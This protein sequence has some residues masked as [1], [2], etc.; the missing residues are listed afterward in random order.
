MIRA[1]I[2]KELREQGLIGLTLLVLGSGLLAAATQANPPVEGA[3]PSDG[4]RYLGVGRLVTLMLAV[5][6]GMVCGGAVFA[7]E[8]EA[9]T[10]AFLESLP[11]S[12]RQIWRAKFTAG[13]TVTIGL[14]AV[15]LAVAASL[16]LVHRLGWAITVSLYALLAFVWGMFGSTAA[17]TTL[18]S[19][20]LAIPA[21]TLT[22]FVALIP[23]ILFFQNPGSMLPRPIGAGIFLVAMFATPLAVSFWLF[24]RS[25]RDRA[26]AET[27]SSGVGFHALYWLTFHQLLVPGLVI[28]LF[29]LS[30]GLALLLPG[31]QPFLAWPSLALA[32]GALSGVTAF[33]DEQSHGSARFWGE[34]RLPLGRAWLLKVTIHLLFCLWLLLLLAIP[35]AVHAQFSRPEGLATNYGGSALSAIFGTPLFDE[36]KQQGW[37]YLVIPAIYGFAAGHLCSLIF[38]KLVVAF[39]VAGVVGGVG[40]ALWGPSLLAGGVKNWQLWIPP[41]IILLT[42]RLLVRA[43]TADR[44]ATRRP[45][46]IL[47]GGSLAALLALVG[48]IGYR[49]LEIPD[50]PHGEDDIR[51]LANLLPL[52]ENVAGRDFKTAAERYSQASTT[53]SS[54]FEKPSA[55]PP[56]P[57]TIGSRRLRVEER[58]ELVPF[59]GWPADDPNLEAWLERLFTSKSSDRDGTS[60]HELV[61]SATERPLGIYEHPQMLGPSGVFGN[62][63]EYARRM[64]VA[65]LAR[66]LQQQ[67]RGDSTAFIPALRSTLTLARTMRNGSV[68]NCLIMGYDIERGALQA[69]DRW[70]E[71][72]PPQAA[73]LRVA[74][75][76]LPSPL[77]SVPAMAFEAATAA[78]QA[79]LLKMAIALLEVC[80]PIEPFDP[81]PQYLAERHVVREALKSLT[82]WL[83]QVLT[84]SPDT[85]GTTDPVIDLLSMAWA[86]PWEK[87][88]TRRLVGLGYEASLSTDQSLLSGRPGAN[89]LT[90]RRTPTDISE[91][92][93]DLRTQRRAAILKL[94]LRGFLVERGKYPENLTALLA[95]GYLH[96]LPPDP[97]DET[98]GFGYRIS[99]GETLRTVPRPQTERIVISRDEPKEQYVP[100]GQAI[101]W[102]VG[103][104][105]I[106]QGGTNPPGP[107]GH[108]PGRPEDSVFLV[109]FSPSGRE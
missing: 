10:M 105:K 85:G 73:W 81:T 43:W 107:V 106:D 19:V 100:P 32:A 76:P 25:D 93:R 53:L 74:A 11:S 56:P 9:G 84:L 99:Q 28:S 101:I 98:R 102:S 21:A 2:W 71:N 16:G 91:M 49:V 27:R 8:R 5:T 103:L 6:A 72:L 59:R 58:L 36:L 83:P 95:T 47:I 20:G 18:G 50:S 86:V 13:F 87:E 35:L 57:Q 54:L 15:L 108:V 109:P 90:A 39:A 40:A 65:L 4:I 60:W 24:T 45:L 51:Y 63:L 46:G 66:G 12:R 80:D 29:A 94:A 62:S 30:L 38:R 104:D 77:E 3:N 68:I 88:R 69:L 42:A 67:A 78:E 64:T 82:Q 26:G 75:V 23:V 17:R 1:I 48:G 79:R 96:R 33:A 31:I 61:A 41:I 97:Y 52:E 22:A 92:D 37:K 89:L 14:I 34:Q 70:L 44:L 7:A 55:L